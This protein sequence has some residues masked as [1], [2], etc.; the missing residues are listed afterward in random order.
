MHHT[1]PFALDDILAD[2][3]LNRLS[4][5]SANITSVI[6]KP[7]Y[8]LISGQSLQLSAFRAHT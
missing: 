7:T 6:S 2:I 1:D 3:L 8:L 5:T 4:R